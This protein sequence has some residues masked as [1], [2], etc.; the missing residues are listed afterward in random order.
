[1]KILPVEAEL[2][3]VGGH[4]CVTK[5]IIDFR[6]FENARFDPFDFKPQID[7]RD[8]FFFF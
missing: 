7:E 1:M 2:F 3:H 6:N 4:T 5:L 8:L